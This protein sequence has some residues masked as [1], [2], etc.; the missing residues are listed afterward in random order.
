MNIRAVGVIMMIKNSCLEYFTL[1]ELYFMFIKHFIYT[2]IKIKQ[3][4]MYKKNTS[5][6]LAKRTDLR[7]IIKLLII[8]T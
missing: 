3:N 7:Q 5:K 6:R 4:R 1:S 2:Y 8:L